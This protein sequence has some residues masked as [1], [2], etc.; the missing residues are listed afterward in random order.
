MA[1]HVWTYE[2]NDNESSHA[3]SFLLAAPAVS[4][5]SAVLTAYCRKYDPY[6]CI[7]GIPVMPALFNTCKFYI[8]ICF[9]LLGMRTMAACWRII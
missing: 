1:M 6:P 7:L 2:V 9:V 4:S 5:A 3:D 8:F